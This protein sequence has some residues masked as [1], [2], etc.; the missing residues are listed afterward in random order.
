MIN[1]AC[2]APKV[3]MDEVSKYTDFEYALA[4]L[5]LQDREYV[6]YFRRR[7]TD[8]RSII[9]DNSAF[10]LLEPLSHEEVLEARDIILRENFERRDKVRVIAPD[11]LGNRELTVLKAAQFRSIGDL[12]SCDVLVVLQGSSVEDRF[13][14]YKE[15]RWNRFTEIAIPV[16]WTR[17]NGKPVP[18]TDESERL[19]LIRKIE[20]V[21]KGFIH[22]H[23][24]GCT[25]FDDSL[26]EYRTFKTV[27]SMDTSYP[28]LAAWEGRDLKDDASKSKVKMNEI[29]LHPDQGSKELIYKNILA[30]KE[31]IDE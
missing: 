26:A 25:K 21:E 18:N 27:R 17:V 10:E 14:C 16:G 15:Y 19:E 7:L 23:L 28:V 6:Q 30:F 24:L 11:V 31:M 22:I 13:Q 1:L 20:E 2:E 5:I 8:G 12:R 29:F 9:L 3:W 4:H